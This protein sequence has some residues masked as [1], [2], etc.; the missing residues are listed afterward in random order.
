MDKKHHS[1]EDL[2]WRRRNEL[3]ALCTALGHFPQNHDFESSDIRQQYPGLQNW[4]HKQRMRPLENEQIAALTAVPGFEWDPREA[5]WHRT[6]DELLDYFAR[7]GHLPRF[8]SADPAERRLADWF[9][10]QKRRLQAGQIPHSLS[11]ALLSAI[12]Q[13]RA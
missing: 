4:I 12:R 6:L 1:R 11:A 3:M 5:Q 7:T 13:T 9:A 8:R 2:W 10:R